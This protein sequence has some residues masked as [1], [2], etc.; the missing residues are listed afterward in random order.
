[1]KKSELKIAHA[2]LD[3]ESESNQ[4]KYHLLLDHLN[5]SANFSE[6][7]AEKFSNGDWAKAAA[8]L[9]DLGKGSS[10]FQEYI[11]KVTGFEAPEEVMISQNADQTIPV[12][13]QFGLS[14]IGRACQ[15]RCLHILF[16]DIMP[17][18]LIG[19]VKLEEVDVSANALIYPTEK[20][21]LLLIKTGSKRQPASC[22][23]LRHRPV[24]RELISKF[25]IY[26]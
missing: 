26:G 10:E 8:L 3:E 1:M 15:E 11:R 2:V 21:Y 7:F 19:I 17:D 16:P 23:F 6:K 24:T 13:V 20:T 25:F 22:N 14:K 5:G 9:H 4:L 12:M 18:C